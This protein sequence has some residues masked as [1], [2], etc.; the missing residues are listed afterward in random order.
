MRI[1][2]RGATAES[3]TRPHPGEKTGRPGGKILF[4]LIFMLLAALWGPGA[5]TALG[6]ETPPSVSLQEAEAVTGPL[7]YEQAV[8]LALRRSP[9]FTKSSLEIEVK[10]LDE[11]DSKFDMIPPVTFRTQ[12]YVTRPTRRDFSNRP[13]TLSFTS[14][15][16]NPVES[17]FTLRAR[18][19]FTQIAI[20]AHMQVVTEGIRRLGRMFLEMDSLSQAA[21][22]QEGLIDLARRNLE[23]FQNRVRIGAGTSLEV[24]IA[25]RELAGAKAEKDR[26]ASSRKRLQERM[27]AFIGLKADQPLDLDCKD[28]RRQ[29]RGDFD[30]AAVS[31]EQAR[32]RSYLLK[33]AELKKE[34][35]NYNILMARARLLPSVFMGATTPD[36][37]SGVQSRELFFSVGL[38][39]PVWDGFKRVRNIS[40]QKTIFRQ[41][42]VEKEEKALELADKW[43][44]VQENLRAAEVDRKAALDLE[45][46]ARLKERQSEIRYHTGGEPLTIYLEGR[47]NLVEAQRN[48]LRKNLDYDLAILGL[49]HLSGDLGASYVD[50]RSWQQ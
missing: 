4:T 48:T 2:T 6:K 5:D 46:L 12:Y 49:R 10:R 24:R 34:L 44:D 35:Q 18:K 8:R 25:T 32:D 40:R 38:E 30:P 14:S 39:V 33:I 13:Y 3:R 23:Y 26:I 27:K 37:L 36:P 45:E 29:V 7:N 22:R 16:Y 19:I 50:A 11:K 47:K 43:F 15:N 17:Y 20:L 31:L 28:A 9:F 1:N 42:G 41:F 21:T